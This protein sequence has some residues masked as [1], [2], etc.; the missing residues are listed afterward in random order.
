MDSLWLQKPGITDGECLE[1]AKEIGEATGIAIN[2]EGIYRWIQFFPSRSRPSLSVSNCYL[3][4]FRSGEIKIRGLEARRSDAPPLIRNVQEEMIRILAGADTFSEYRTLLP[5]A[6]ELFEDTMDDLKR[7]RI[8][9]R[10]LVRSQHLTKSPEEYGRATLPAIVA[11]ELVSRGIRLRAGETIRYIITAAGDRDPSSRAKA[12][13]P[14]SPDTGYDRKKYAELLRRATEPL[15]KP[16][17]PVL[18]P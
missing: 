2:L 7:G 13:P 12:Y 5:R 16:L 15:L 9:L 11:H 14:A 1:L 4:V 18:L 6:I 3:G 8:P 10:E 17:G